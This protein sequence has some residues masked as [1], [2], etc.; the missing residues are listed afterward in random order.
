MPHIKQ[1]IKKVMNDE[2]QKYQGRIFYFD[3][4][5]KKL[6]LANWIVD[7][8]CYDHYS[9]ELHHVIKFTRY[10]KNK[11][12]YK[13]QGFEMCLVLI[14]KVMHQ[15]LE[16][17]EFELSNDKFYQTYGIH[18]Y[19]LLFKK[20]DFLN[21]KYPEILKYKTADFSLCESDLSCFDE[22]YNESEVCCA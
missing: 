4:D 12:W 13:N 18:K 11:Q 15:H 17:P 16:N 5:T 21:G 22:I 2:I 10:E 19:K 3:K 20:K 8:K 14:P 6:C 1:K 9:F 7:T